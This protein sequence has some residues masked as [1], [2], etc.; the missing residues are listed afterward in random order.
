MPIPPPYRGPG[1]GQGKRPARTVEWHLRKIFAKL[2]IGSRRELHAV[3]ASLGQDGQLPVTPNR[4]APSGM[5]TERAALARWRRTV[6]A[7]F[8]LGGITISAWGSRLPAIKA[9]L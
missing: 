2:G 4:P 9:G 3:L 8:G 7:A 1:Y 6:T 5:T